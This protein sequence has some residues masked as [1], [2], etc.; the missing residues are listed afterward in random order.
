[1]TARTFGRHWRLLAAA[2]IAL[3]ATQAHAI[4]GDELARDLMRLHSSTDTRDFGYWLPAAAF[5]A[6]NPNG[7]PADNAAIIVQLKGYELFLF[8]RQHTD[9][10]GTGT[11][12]DYGPNPQDHVRL[13]LADGRVLQAEREAD[14]PPPVVVLANAV[15]STF[16]KRGEIGRAMRFAAFKIPASEQQPRIDSTKPSMVTLLLD[17]IPLVWHLPLAGAGPSAIDPDSGERFPGGY[18]FN[19]YTGAPLKRE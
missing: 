5:G 14:L 4:D 15:K 10:T 8:A 11:A 3:G 7:T 19:P 1:M 18:S 16:A 12:F 2:A 6:L 13:K 17:G 9:E